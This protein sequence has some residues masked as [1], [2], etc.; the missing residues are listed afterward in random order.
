MLL[1]DVVEWKFND[2]RKFLVNDEKRV[3]YEII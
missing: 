3:S 2:E 1:G